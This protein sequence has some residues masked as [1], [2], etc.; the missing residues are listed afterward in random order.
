[1]QSISIKG[2]SKQAA[3]DSKNAINPAHSKNLCTRAVF[4]QNTQKILRH[5]ENK[6]ID[7]SEEKDLLHIDLDEDLF[8][9][10]S[11]SEPSIKS[12]VVIPSPSTILEAVKKA[13]PAVIPVQ[14][15]PPENGFRDFNPLPGTSFNPFRTKSRLSS[16][17]FKE[18]PKA[19]AKKRNFPVIKRSF[20]NQ[21]Q[22]KFS[23]QTQSRDI[24]A[25]IRP[26]LSKISSKDIK[27]FFVDDFERAYSS[28]VQSQPLRQPILT[29]SVINNTQATQPQNITIHYHVNYHGNKKRRTQFRPQE[30]NIEL[31]SRGQKRR[32]YKRL[33]KE[34]SKT[35][36]P[37]F[38]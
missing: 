29:S 31:M 25:Q 34:A 17:F 20:S 30:T 21:V 18:I 26:N 23:N 6:P 24:E 7:E 2:Q 15:I 4:E 3:F 28:T 8:V 13:F 37:R 38:E 14:P 9:S 10:D 12:G 11:D 22:Q 5:I 33:A 16:D 36:I 35:E 27:D 32:Y 1:M 19:P